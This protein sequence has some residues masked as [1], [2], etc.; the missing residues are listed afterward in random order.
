MTTAT[1][2]Q[3][4]QLVVGDLV[5]FQFANHKKPQHATIT[6]IGPPIDGHATLHLAGSPDIDSLSVERVEPPPK[7]ESPRYIELFKGPTTTSPAVPYGTIPVPTPDPWDTTNQ[8]A[9]LPKPEPK[10]K[11]K[12]SAGPRSKLRPAEAPAPSHK[13]SVKPTTKGTRS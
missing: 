3:G 9:P 12:S 2:R 8:E 10:P 4:T 6:A 11:P 13:K 5:T 7:S 1:D